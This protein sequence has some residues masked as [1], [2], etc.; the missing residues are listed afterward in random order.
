MQ[1]QEMDCWCSGMG[2]G[3]LFGI[4]CTLCIFFK[5]DIFHTVYSLYVIYIIMV[6][7]IESFPFL[8]C[9]SSMEQALP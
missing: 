7:K 6:V 1:S 5:R 3:P 2:Y 9:H 8:L 4:H